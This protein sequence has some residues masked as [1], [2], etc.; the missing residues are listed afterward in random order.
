MIKK[1][2][3]SITGLHVA[4]QG[5]ICGHQDIKT[6]VK[7]LAPYQQR[8]VNVQRDDISFL[9]TRCCYKPGAKTQPG[10]STRQPVTKQF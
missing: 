10:I 9:A 5:S 6:Q 1:P 2:I 3:N 4:F 8:V 7:L